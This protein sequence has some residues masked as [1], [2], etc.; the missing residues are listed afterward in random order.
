MLTL[1]HK[2]EYPILVTFSL[3][4]LTLVKYLWALL[5]AS[6]FIKENYIT[7][8]WLV[9]I[10]IIVATTLAVYFLS[11]VSRILLERKFLKLSNEK[12]SSASV[13]KF[14][15][16]VIFILI[17][18]VWIAYI[19]WNFWY[20]LNALL[21]WAWIWGLAIALAAQKSITN[22]FGAVTIILNKP[23]QIWDYVSINGQEWT[24]RDIGLSYVTLTDRAGH[25]V[26]MPNENIITS[27]I[28]NMSVRESRRVDFIIWVVYSTSLEKVKEW[29]DVIESL[30]KRYQEKREISDDIRVT[31]DTFN[32]FSLDIKVTYFSLVWSLIEFNH[33]KQ[34]I[35]FEIKKIFE[36]SWIEMAFPT[37]E[38]II[39]NETVPIKMSPKK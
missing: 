1:G 21:A 19:L 38:M 22:I 16:K 11:W 13:L 2:K 12:S 3:R 9:N 34:E 26:M 10:Q 25:Q 6:F 17:W 24:V 37:S 32:S 29:V 39:K 20:N 5:I 15:N 28:A 8:N 14:W 4:F 23:F 18:F 30:L 36:Q 27:S 7:R 33:Q 31:F 35:N